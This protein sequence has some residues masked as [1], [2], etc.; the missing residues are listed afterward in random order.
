M[1]ILK[2]RDENGK[3]HEVATF[4][5]E[6]GDSVTK[7]YAHTNFCNMLKGTVTGQAIRISDA[8]PYK[9]N[10]KVT[11]DSPPVTVSQY[12]KNLFKHF[13]E[14]TV[15]GVTLSRVDDYFVLNGTCTAD[16][17]FYVDDMV[18][19]N[20]TY[21]L[22][23]NNPAGGNA[24][25][26]LLYTS[27]YIDLSQV[28]ATSSAFTVETNSYGARVYI[29]EGVTYD[30]FII[31][32]QLEVGSEPTEY[33]PYTEPLIFP[34]DDNS[35]Y[36]K[37]GVVFDGTDTTLM[38]QGAEITVEYNRDITKAIAQLEALATGV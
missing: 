24:H 34:H 5:G 36:E 16:M 29:Y 14:E 1:A 2:I 30:N 33:A 18:L 6:K 17:Y 12:G 19:T 11:T 37:K 13:A 27:A 26:E 4:K 23:A 21:C 10:V 35:P 32:P 8:V 28:N 9:H 38:A 15:N 7:E 3:V 22:S 25:I 20:G 31:K